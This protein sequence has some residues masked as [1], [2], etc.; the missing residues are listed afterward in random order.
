MIFGEKIRLFREKRGITAKGLAFA[1]DID[2]STLNRIEN[3]KVTTFK[4]QF[5]EK[6]VKF[7]EIDISELFSPKENAI[8]QETNTM[9]NG[10]K[11]N[12]TNLNEKLESLF[13]KLLNVKENEIQLLKEQISYLKNQNFNTPA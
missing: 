8:I 7:L 9:E 13:E 6:L 12:E 1:L 2:L 5:L 3:G 4:P 11:I 10:N